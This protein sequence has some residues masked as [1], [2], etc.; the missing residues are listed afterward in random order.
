MR[1]PLGLGIF[2]LVV[3]CGGGC[4]HTRLAHM[5]VEAPNK[6]K[7]CSASMD[8]DGPA[9][10][11]I[12]VDQQF[13]VSAG[14]PAASIAV[15][16]MEPKDGKVPRGT[17][18]VLHGLWAQRSMMLRDTRM[19]AQAG[20]RAVLVDL[21]GQGRSTGDYLTFGVVE[22][23]DV[24]QVIDD[25]E[26]RK[27]I[28]GHLGLFGLSFGAATALEVA[29]IDPRVKA[30]VALASFATMRE[31]VPHFG[32]QM[33][34]ALTWYLSAEDCRAIEDEAGK[35]AAFDPDA[36][37]PLAA[38]GRTHVPVLLVHGTFDLI[39]PVDQAKELHAA[40]ADHS[41]LLLVPGAGHLTL[42]MDLDGTVAR[43]AREW[44]GRYLN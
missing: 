21:R 13:R 32:H 25:L 31:E 5:I 26:Q 16:V 17:V 14:P 40:A 41:E 6:G 23:R 29:G 44:F 8:L 12:G 42:L 20:Y 27:L 10:H 7:P 15:W 37:S 28:A 2:I 34:P 38:I 11:A 24:V 9:L 35:L 33:L 30:V 18:I 22:A 1:Q 3:L 19:L 36:A 43:K 4:S 39:I